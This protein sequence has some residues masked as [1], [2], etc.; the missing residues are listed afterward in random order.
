MT[1]RLLRLLAALVVLV[2]LLPCELREA[3]PIVG[4]LAGDCCDDDEDDA[5]VDCCGTAACAFVA[6]LAP[7]AGVAAAP[8]DPGLLLIHRPAPV[9]RPSWRAG[10]PPTPPPIA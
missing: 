1:V 7:P 9:D 4:E 6:A 5:E 8:P 3:L 2:G 10:P